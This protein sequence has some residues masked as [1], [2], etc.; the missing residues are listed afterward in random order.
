MTDPN[1]HASPESGAGV[2]ELLRLFRDDHAAA[3]RYAAACLEKA[4]AA[5]P[6]L[7]AFEYLPVDVSRRP[8]PLSGVPV[9]IKDLAAHQLGGELLLRGCRTGI[10]GRHS[11]AE[12][13]CTHL[14]AGHGI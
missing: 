1:A 5:E 9:A 6:V 4:E 3:D 11:P 7:K 8:G 14:T 12:I 10:Q 2:L 13:A